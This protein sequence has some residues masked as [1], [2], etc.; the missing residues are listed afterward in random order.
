MGAAIEMPAR[1]APR[2]DIG[3]EPPPDASLAAVALDA[4]GLCVVLVDADLRVLFAS[5]AALSMAE[6][7]DCGF[8][9]T[10]EITGGWRLLV[11]DRR[12]DAAVLRC[13]VADAIERGAE[14][15]LKLVADA[16]PPRK[17]IRCVLLVSPVAAPG[18]DGAALVVIEGLG[19]PPRLSPALLRAL[20]GLSPAEAEVASDLAGGATAEDVAR[21]RCV[22]LDTVR[23]QIRSILTKSDSA[24][25]RAFEHRLGTILAVH[26]RRPA[27]AGGGTP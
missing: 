26:R 25:L 12:E 15:A 3:A 22:A 18:A 20:F 5:A 10:S 14:G 8:S 23:T 4:L 24:N 11:P 19:A 27:D 21:A 7:P 9:L 13:L 6:L 16:T 17:R 2:T 1:P